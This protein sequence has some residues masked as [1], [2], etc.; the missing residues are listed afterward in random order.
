MKRILTIFLMVLMGTSCADEKNGNESAKPESL[1]FTSKTIEK[2]LDD[3]D[4]EKGDCT[5]ISLSFPVAENGNGAAEKIN[6]KIED[7]I[8]RTLDFQDDRNTDD[9]E[10]LAANFIEDYKEAAEEFPDHELAWEAT[11]HGKVHYRSSAI[12]SIQFNTDMFTGGAHGYRSTN[13]VN[14]DPE[15][16]E[17][18]NNTKLFSTEFED[19]VEKDF[20]EKQGIPLDENINSTGL[21]FENDEFHL[22]ENIG[23]NESQITLYYNA[24]DIAP[25]SD[26]HFVMTYQKSEVAQFLKIKEDPSSQ[27]K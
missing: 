11:I 3:C 27:Q 5:F 10:K 16:G 17:I 19:F 25:Y 26:G 8:V 21:L 13:F 20:R 24:Y 4:P 6:T 9:A 2:K 15:T 14:F 22:P 18:L 7:F 1:S 12:I 23:I